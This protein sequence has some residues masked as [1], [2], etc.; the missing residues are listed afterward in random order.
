METEGQPNARASPDAAANQSERTSGDGSSNTSIA[1]AAY[2]CV[3]NR[4]APRPSRFG[5]RTMPCRDGTTNAAGRAPQSSDDVELYT[6]CASCGISHQ[7]EPNTRRPGR[8]ILNHQCAPA[9]ATRLCA[10][11]MLTHISLVKFLTLHDA[12]PPALAAG[13]P[14][15]D[16]PPPGPPRQGPSPTRG[17]SR[18]RRPPAGPAAAGLARASAA[19]R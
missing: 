11:F 17:P 18:D 19:T 7:P 16:S 15:A 8:R 13:G 4:V 12:R 5:W 6:S 3:C 2:W 9:G 14:C 10:R 1:E